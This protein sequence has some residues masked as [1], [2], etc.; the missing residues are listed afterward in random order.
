MWIYIY[1]C[2]NT[3]PALMVHA[4]W[5]ASTYNL[6]LILNIQCKFPNNEPM[7]GLFL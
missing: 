5:K 6:V 2:P 4:L 3:K 1:E 7:G